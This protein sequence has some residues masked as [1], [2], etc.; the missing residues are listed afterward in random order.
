MGICISLNKNKNKN[1]KGEVYKNI[2]MNLDENSKQII[3]KTKR[4]KGTGFLCY[5]PFPDK[6]HL[7]P[8]L[9]TNNHILNEEDISIGKKIKFSINN[10]E[11]FYEIIIDDS[12]KTFT[13]KQPYDITIVQLKP[14]D[15]LDLDSLLEIDYELIKS[16]MKIKKQIFQ[17]S[18]SLYFNIT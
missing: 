4:G 12:R 1:Q 17:R 15:K 8:V 2:K 9:I 6:I 10:E 5:I 7:L 3:E 14:K 11:K 16:N 13:K 18:F